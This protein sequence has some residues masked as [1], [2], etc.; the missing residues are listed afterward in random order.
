MFKKSY[1]KTGKVCRTTFKYENPEQAQKACLAGDFN[2]WSADAQPMKKLKDGS[3]SVTLSLDAGK[4][5]AFRYVLDDSIWVNDPEA[6]SYIANE[7]GEDNSQIN[8]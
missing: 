3:F 8:V 6:D 5:Y 4:T 2:A 7:Y 1:S